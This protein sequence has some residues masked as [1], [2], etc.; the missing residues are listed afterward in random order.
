MEF[1]CLFFLHW[2][3]SGK[4]N[5]TRQTKWCRQK[6]NEKECPKSS[7]IFTK[8]TNHICQFANSNMANF[9]QW[10]LC[11][12]HYVKCC[13]FLPLLHISC[14]LCKPICLCVSVFFIFVLFLFLFRSFSTLK[15]ALMYICAC[16]VMLCRLAA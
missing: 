6:V 5:L 3:K 9:E 14:L 4:N 2:S 13:M 10:I 15:T 12:V 1:I 7:E 11:S 16:D 8:K